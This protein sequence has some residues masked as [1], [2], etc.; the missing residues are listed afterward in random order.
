MFDPKMLEEIA[1][2][3]YRRLDERH[4]EPV[5]GTVWRFGPYV[6]AVLSD[7]G[8]SAGHASGQ[9]RQVLYSDG[10]RMFHCFDGDEEFCG[11]LTEAQ[12]AE[13][14]AYTETAAAGRLRASIRA[15]IGAAEAGRT[16]PLTEDML[17][18]LE[19]PDP[20]DAVLE[21]LDR[22]VDLLS[23]V[24]AANGNV[25]VDGVETQ[26]DGVDVEADRPLTWRDWVADPDSILRS[27]M[28][29]LSPS[30]V[31]TAVRPGQVWAFGGDNPAR[32]LVRW[33]E[34]D[35]AF[36]VEVDAAGNTI[37]EA[38]APAVTFMLS[39]GGHYR[40]VKDAPGG[41]FYIG[42]SNA[43]CIRALASIDI[44]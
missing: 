11:G 1:A 44:D 14:V 35:H 27:I 34:A 42:A 13:A 9:C 30:P 20:L 33:V 12:L 24:V 7:E 16:V 37:N 6:V 41:A 36:L 38:W 19:G 43:T 29:P 15:G 18:S 31:P 5:P 3:L 25:C 17:T 4:Y 28:Y 2:G 8:C 23:P 32:L 40:L 39:P 21:W 10:V 26:R 22:I